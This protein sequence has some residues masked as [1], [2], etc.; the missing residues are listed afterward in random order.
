MNTP[1]DMAANAPL[2]TDTILVQGRQCGTCTL[3]C[4]LL[5][6]KEINKPDWTWRTHCKPGRGCEIGRAHV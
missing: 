4:K 1:S 5:G 2:P 3:C 6:I